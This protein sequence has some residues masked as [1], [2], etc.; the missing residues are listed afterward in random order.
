MKQLVCWL[1]LWLAPFAGAE[2]L[3]VY[4]HSL[5]KEV[6]VMADGSL[7]PQPHG[8]FRAFSL[9]LVQTAMARMALPQP[10]REIPL[11]RGVQQLSTDA[12]VMLFTLF[13]TTERERR[14]Q[15][16]GPLF[17]DQTLLYERVD[18][19]S[20]A[21]S[22]QDALPQPVCAL[23][24]GSHEHRLRELGFQHIELSNSYEAC[25]RM[26]QAGRVRLA[27]IIRT[28]YPGKLRMAEVPAGLLRSSGLVLMENESY[29]AVSH[30]VPAS[31]VE[32]WNRQI[33]DIRA[34]AL[35]D[36]LKA[37]YLP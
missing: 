37:L 14:Y 34:S 32:R 11:V 6:R 22:L 1:A 12:P 8:G 27:A 21:K 35:Y 26:L 19:P 24:G 10:V 9:A 13:R 15:W 33:A 7:Q 16:I 31:E 28:D 20:R 2:E 3:A 25:L 4:T 17:R 23:R 36:E 5:D 18:R 30:A 29:I